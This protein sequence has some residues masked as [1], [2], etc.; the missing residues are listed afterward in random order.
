[1]IFSNKKGVSPLVATM[2]LIA[3]A[4]ALGA[5]V[6]NLGA[7]ITTPDPD[8]H[9]SSECT[10]VNF[11]LIGKVCYSKE[12]QE[13]KIAVNNKEDSIDI[14][15][16]EIGIQSSESYYDKNTDPDLEI[17]IPLIPDQKQNILIPYKRLQK[18]QIKEIRV[19]PIIDKDE[20]CIKR[21]VVVTEITDC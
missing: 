19:V 17:K 10:N 12:S 20:A 18:G 7:N 11:E 16:V 1:M 2:L 3:F 6:I 21:K 4:I 15:G 14:K 5:V 8:V 13:I 9:K